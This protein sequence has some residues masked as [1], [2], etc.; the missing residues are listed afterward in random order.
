[1]TLKTDFKKEIAAY[2]AKSGRFDIVDVPALRY[3]MIDGHGDPN[4]GAFTDATGALYP[5]AYRLKFAAKKL[6]RD[7]VVMPLEGLW[8]SGDMTAF[9]AARDKSRWDWTLMI[10]VPDWVDDEMFAG[11]GGG[12]S[13]V[14]LATLAEG[15]CVQTL[16]VGSYDDEA[17]TLARMHDEFIPANGL[18]MTGKHH[19]IY[20]SDA[21]RVAPGKLRT[22]LRQP[23]EAVTAAVPARPASMPG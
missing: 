21:R 18:R 19:E 10:M 6:G 17:E 16:H 14:R 11:A 9:T 12:S 8:W 3:L 22:I 23:V 1:M 5:L 13:A 15:R 2:S 4:T 20:L 7:H